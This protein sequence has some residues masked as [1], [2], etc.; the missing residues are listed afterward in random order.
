[1]AIDCIGVG[2]RLEELC[3]VVVTLCYLGFGRCL[4]LRRFSWVERIEVG[5]R[6]YTEYICSFLVGFL[7]KRSLNLVQK[8]G[9]SCAP[10]S[11]PE[12]GSPGFSKIDRF[13]RGCPRRKTLY[14][15]S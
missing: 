2:L 15:G 1:M 7:I 6:V 4:G 5:Y 3:G 8:G 12:G 11:P 13:C 9:D 14:L 10:A